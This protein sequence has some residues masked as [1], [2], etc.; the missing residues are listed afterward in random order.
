MKT[1]KYV[2]ALVADLLAAAEVGDDA[3]AEAARRLV[4]AVAPSARLRMLEALSEAAAEVSGRLPSG[5]VEA[6]LVGGEVELVYVAWPGEGE[7]PAVEEDLTARVTLRL[8]ESLKERVEA[9][10]GREGVSIN[11]WLVRA[12]RR[13]LERRRGFGN[14]LTGFAES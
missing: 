13:D 14:R 1:S 2:D 10:A 7:P 8:P 3:V 6:R 12:A 9:A 4:R 5:S 11:A